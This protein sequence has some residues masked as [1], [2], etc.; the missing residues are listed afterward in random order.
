M[1]PPDR[2]VPQALSSFLNLRD[3][4]VL[5]VGAGVVG[6]HKILAL[7]EAG[8]RVR[9]VAPMA[10]DSLKALAEAGRIQWEKRAFVE[11]DVEGAWLV[12][13]ATSDPVAQRSAASA[14]AGHRVFAVAVDDPANSSAFA[15]AVVSRPPMLVAISSS[16]ASPALSRLVRELLEHLLPSEDWIRHARRLRIEWR[17]DGLP[18]GERFGRLVRDFALRRGMIL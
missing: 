5:V 8:A 13:A 12:I 4:P 17:R 11:A 18:L 6:E 15:G 16:G 1:S 7:L 10:T 2:A 3:K 9:V 14:A